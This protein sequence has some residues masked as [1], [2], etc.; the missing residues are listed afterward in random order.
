MTSLAGEPTRRLR[1]DILL[2]LPRTKRA[3]YGGAYLWDKPD[4]TGDDGW[5]EEK[6]A[7]RD[8]PRRIALDI[9]SSTSN[10][11]HNKAAKLY[12]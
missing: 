6:E 2:A 10:N 3:E 7:V 11:A 9:A 4:S 5:D 8:L 12:F 1:V